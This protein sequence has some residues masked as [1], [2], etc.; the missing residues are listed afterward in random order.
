MSIAALPLGN[1]E[2]LLSRE[3]ALGNG[4]DGVAQAARTSNTKPQKIFFNIVKNLGAQLLATCGTTTSQ[5]QPAIFGCHTG[6][7]PMAAFTNKTTWLVCAFHDN[8]FPR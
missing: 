2:A 5:H 3:A 8:N 4:G 6:A 7:K 1:W